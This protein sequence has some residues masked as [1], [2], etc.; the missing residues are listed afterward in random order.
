MI[1]ALSGAIVQLMR[2]DVYDCIGTSGTMRSRVRPEE[3][4]DEVIG[5]TFCT[6]TGSLRGSSIK[7]QESGDGDGEGNGVRAISHIEMEWI[8][9]PLICTSG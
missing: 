6:V 8:T 4:G 1:F 5:S 3:K 2:N 7:K 9:R